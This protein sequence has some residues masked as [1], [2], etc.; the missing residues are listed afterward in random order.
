M[1]L[2]H[3]LSYRPI[4]WRGNAFWIPVRCWHDRAKTS[5]VDLSLIGDV[6]TAAYGAETEPVTTDFDD[7]DNSALADGS[8][9]LKLDSATT[10]S[11]TKPVYLF[12]ITATGGA[13]SPCTVFR[14]TFLV[15]GR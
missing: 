1:S 14:G 4:A 5:P 9:I 11:L 3:R 15:D 13:I 8:I 10:L 7:V 12:E 6:W 2:P